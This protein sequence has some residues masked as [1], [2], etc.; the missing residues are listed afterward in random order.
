MKKQRIQK[1][2][3]ESGIMSRR[4]AESLIL[5]K[6]IKV[7]GKVV[8]PGYKVDVLKDKIFIDEKQVTLSNENRKYYIM[9]NKPRGYITTTNDEK[10]RRCVMDLL[11]DFP[12]RIYPVGRL[13]RDSEG[14]LLLTNDGNFHNSVLHPSKKVNKLYKVVV[15]SGLSDEIVTK[16]SSGVVID[17]KKTLPAIIRVLV[18]TNQYSEFEIT[19]TEGKNRQIRKMCETVGLNVKKLKRISIGPLKLGNLGLGKYRELKPS[20][21]ISLRNAI[22]K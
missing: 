12:E 10:N 21:L 19:I 11:K 16:L 22:G 13:D 6:R 17:G 15:D 7:N 1:V 8:E 4:K 2:L 3:S 14:L 5:T 9:L 20:E 18:D